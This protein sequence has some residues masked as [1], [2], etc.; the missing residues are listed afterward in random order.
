MRTFEN[1]RIKWRWLSEKETARINSKFKGKSG[2]FSLEKKGIIEKI[3]S[4]LFSILVS[5]L[6]FI[7]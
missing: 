5:N 7:I 6:F 4:S 1:D 2:I 3:V